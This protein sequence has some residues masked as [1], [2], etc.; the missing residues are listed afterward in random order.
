MK[1]ILIFIY[2]ICLFQMG[3]GKAFDCSDTELLTD[4]VACKDED[5]RHS[6]AQIEEYENAFIKAHEQCKTQ[7]CLRELY[8][9]KAEIAEVMKNV[10]KPSEKLTDRLP[11][12]AGIRQLVG[13]GKLLPLNK[14]LK[15]KFLKSD[16]WFFPYRSH[17]PEHEKK[18][19]IKPFYLHYSNCSRGIMDYGC[20]SFLMTEQFDSL[21]E[22]VGGTIELYIPKDL[23]AP[24]N[25][26]HDDF[27]YLN[28]TTAELGLKSTTFCYNTDDIF[29]QAVCWNNELSQMEQQ[30]NELLAQALKEIGNENDAYDL[31]RH[32]F[33]TMQEARGCST[34]S[35]IFTN[36]K[37]RLEYLQNKEYLK[38]YQKEPLPQGCNL[39]DF[40]E[41]YEVYAVQTHGATFLAEFKI[42]NRKSA[43]KIDLWVNRPQKKVV[44]ILNAR[45][46]VVW[47]LHI[48]PQTEIL[49]V[50]AGGYHS[51]MIRG[52]SETMFADTGHCLNEYIE[53]DELRRKARKL[54]LL[55]GDKH[56]YYLLDKS[57]IYSLDK[58]CVIGERL[59]NQAYEFMPDKTIGLGIPLPLLTGQEGLDQQVEYGNLLELN[60]SLALYLKRDNVVVTKTVKNPQSRYP[61]DLSDKEPW[62]CAELPRQYACKDNGSYIA[63]GNVPEQYRCRKKSY[64]M[65]EQ[66]DKLPEGLN[67]ANAVQIYIPKDMK[68]P[69]EQGENQFY[70]LNKTRKEMTEIWKHPSTAGLSLV[71]P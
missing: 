33:N 68:I 22:G 65:W 50:L 31:A 60:R 69:R 67:G 44:L 10:L 21:P 45:E 47:N 15:E 1:N 48:T 27:Y 58:S 16:I 28:K 71:Y 37:T 13:E 19:V 25:P 66:M 14:T 52:V 7:S 62:P 41:D 43:K 5:I 6:M 30:G 38:E 55:D 59:D 8:R 17:N 26:E 56:N 63:C 54:G 35:C 42:D 61:E 23:I 32:D 12:R 51:Q 57:Y 20:M 64:L 40:S 9:K 70:R 49:A 29:K 4:L 34:L 18:G 3:T 11:D 46:P 53:G 24:K 39:P 2:F 36:Y